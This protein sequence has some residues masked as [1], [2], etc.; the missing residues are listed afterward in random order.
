M[1]GYYVPYGYMGW[2]AILGRYILFA[3][4]AEY[5]ELMQLSV[6]DGVRELWLMGAM[7]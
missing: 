2:V 5:A 7:E 1:K 6:K 4:E 3:T